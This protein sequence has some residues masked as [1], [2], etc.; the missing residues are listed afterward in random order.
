MDV[1]IPRLDRLVPPYVS[2]LREDEGSV[3]SCARLRERELRVYSPFPAQLICDS[4]RPGTRSV[5]LRRRT[6]V[7]VLSSFFV[8]AA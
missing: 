7:F 3:F 8:P 6:V 2:L 4:W 5:A 1:A